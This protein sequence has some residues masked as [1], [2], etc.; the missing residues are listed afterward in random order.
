M[1]CLNYWSYRFIVLVISRLILQN[2]KKESLSKKRRKWWNRKQIGEKC[3][4][5]R[6]IHDPKHEPI[7]KESEWK[8][9]GRNHWSILLWATVVIMWI[10]TSRAPPPSSHSS[11]FHKKQY[12]AATNFPKIHVVTAFMRAVSLSFILIPA[13][14]IFKVISAVTTTW[15]W[16]SWPMLND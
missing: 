5:R 1:Y 7:R 11:I 6:F 15:W 14:G 13:E 3:I 2:I 10:K 16:W 12:D 4:V 8:K 9:G